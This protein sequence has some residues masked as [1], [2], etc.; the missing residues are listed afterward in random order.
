MF[1]AIAN[2]LYELGQVIRDRITGI[3]DSID[4]SLVSAKLTGFA[5][6]MAQYLNGLFSYDAEGRT[7][8][9]ELS[10][11]L[12]N[13]L[14]TIVAT[15]TAFAIEFDFHQFGVNL[16]DAVNKFFRTFDFAAFANSI[17][18]WVQ[19]LYEMVITA[20]K[21]I[22]WLDV[23]DSMIELLSEL[24]IKTVAIIIGA[25]MIKSVAK[26]VLGFNLV[27]WLGKEL[28][29]LVKGKSISVG[30][31]NVVTTLSSGGLLSGDGFFAKLLNVFALVKGGAGTLHEAMVTMFGTVG[32]V[33]SG[34]ASIIVGAFTAVLNFVSM[35]KDGF[36]WIKE[37]FMVLGTALAAIGAIILGAPA[38]IAGIV[39]AVV[40]AVMTIVVVVKDNWDAICQ[41][42]G[43]AGE[44]FNTNVI[45]PICNFFKD[46]WSTVSLFFS[47]LWEDI[48]NIWNI[49]A[50]WFNTY[51]IEPVVNFFVGLY[52]RVKQIFEGLWIIVQAIWIVVSKWFNDNVITPIVTGF[53]NFYNAVSSF[54][55]NLWAG[56]QSVWSTVSTWFS[57]NVVTPLVNRFQ[58]LWNN[59]STIFS[60]LWT[61]IKS[62]WSSV[63]T[64]FKTN[65]IAPFV[66]GWKTATSTIGGVFTTLWSTIK[67]GLKNAMNNVIAGIES[68]INFIISGINL[69]IGGF[70]KIVSAA[71]SITGSTW[72]GVSTIS[73]VALPRLATGA[74]IPPNK[75]F[76]AILGDQKHGT[77]IEAPLDTIKQAV[78]EVLANTNVGG[79]SQEVVLELD[80]QVLARMALPY[81]KNEVNRKGYS[82]SVSGA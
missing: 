31:E 59:V 1:D 30:L 61:N 54:F 41:W 12:A 27:S 45:T 80:G 8:F 29:R 49:V 71:S 52:N 13:T 73:S 20:I 18:K 68:A 44:W 3:L 74:V 2:N 35:L 24:D 26:T 7:I 6:G 76:M 67:M 75:E 58:T 32:T 37:V 64:W 36:S 15:A 22:N 16:A 38:A 9:G 69:L 66:S 23:Y 60:T 77:N 14:N 43:D 25:M 50:D 17:D 5:T 46:L 21:E 72:S 78:A 4:W 70:N 56:I 63:A 82:L 42:F 11:T 19:G 47:N 51:I 39:A 65:V 57:T 48:K 28:T 34:V 62:V 55:S 79:S 81:F 53:Q 10:K 33:I 40:A